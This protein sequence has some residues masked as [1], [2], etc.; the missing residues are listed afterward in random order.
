MMENYIKIENLS[1]EIKGQIILDNINLS[2]E[3]GKIYGF[4]GRNGSGKTMLFRALTGLIRPTNGTVSIDGKLLHRDISFPESVGILIEYPGFIPEYTGFS[5]LKLLSMIQ[6]NINDNDIRSSISRVGLNPNDKRKFKKYS[7]G[8]KQRLGI[9]QAIMEN[10]DLL[11]L[12]E[13]TNALDEEAIDMICNLLLSL[14]AEGKTILIA[15]HDKETL[16]KISDTIYY[17]ESGE[18]INS[19]LSEE[20]NNND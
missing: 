6:Q 11:V 8:M 13:P 1:K 17:I 20:K 9:A 10:P 3:K 7:L 15:S 4:R 18:I 19:I 12:D 16:Q 2:L 14:K 5:N